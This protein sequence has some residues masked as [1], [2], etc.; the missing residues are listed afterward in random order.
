MLRGNEHTLSNLRLIAGIKKHEYIQTDSDANILSY[1]GHNFVNC[2]SS[3]IYGENFDSTM[4]CLRKVYVDEMPVLL[5]KLMKSRSK[6]ELKKIGKLLEKSLVG[7]ENLK[8]VYQGTDQLAHVNTVIDD[9]AK[10]QLDRLNEFL[11]KIRND[12][13]TSLLAE[14]RSIDLSHSLP[15]PSLKRCATI[16]NKDI[17][18]SSESKTTTLLEELKLND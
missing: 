3:A 2:V 13:E 11:D 6:K 8:I 18:L 17:E 15:I 7:L 16:V 9:F 10:N 5:D 4:R 1:L 12:E 14:D